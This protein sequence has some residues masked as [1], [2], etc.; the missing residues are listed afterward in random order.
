MKQY[1]KAL[2]ALSGHDFKPWE[3]G[4]IIRDLFVLAN[5]EKGK[6]AYAARQFSVAEEVFRDA[7][8]YPENL[9]VGKPD[10]PH[11]EEALYW[12]GKSLQA[13]GKAEAAHDAWQ[14]AADEGRFPSGEGERGGTTS[15]FYAA[16][17]LN[18]LGHADQAA[19][20]LDALASATSQAHAGGYDY[21]LAG[22]VAGYRDRHGQA[23]TDFRRALDLDPSLWQARVELEHI[24]T[25][26]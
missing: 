11:N 6:Q 8:T 9:G 20:I 24:G 2:D 14:Q 13:E 4:R 17:A 15:E 12:L 5:L 19:V 3:G 7:L 16:L 21:Y 22:L 18:R 25:A 23:V 1:D 10:K 26:E